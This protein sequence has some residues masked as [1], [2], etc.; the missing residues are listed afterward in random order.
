MSEYDTQ[1]PK[2]QSLTTRS[3]GSW[4]VGVA[5]YLCL[6]DTHE[7]YTSNTSTNWRSFLESAW[8]LMSLLLWWDL[9]TFLRVVAMARCNFNY[10]CR[11]RPNQSRIRFLTFR[12]FFRSLTIWIIQ[13]CISPNIALS[14]RNPSRESIYMLR[15]K[16]VKMYF[17]KSQDSILV[18]K[19]YLCQARLPCVPRVRKWTWK[20]IIGP[21]SIPLKMKTVT[22]WTLN[23]W[24]SVIHACDDNSWTACAESQKFAAVH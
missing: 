17:D 24:I 14:S 2:S 16:R 19:P 21:N 5:M 9:Y 1:S 10:L 12:L 11:Q 3:L 20:C 8:S 23:P 22:T 6:Q 18:I 15:S 13:I 4:W 7:E